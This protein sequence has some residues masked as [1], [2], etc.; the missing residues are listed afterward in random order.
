MRPT[1]LQ[2]VHGTG[3][4]ASREVV[5]RRLLAEIQYQVTV[6]PTAGT[7][8]MSDHARCPLPL[9]RACI[10]LAGP[11]LF[12]M[13]NALTAL[14][15]PAARAAGLERFSVTIDDGRTG[16]Q[17]NKRYTAIKE[18]RSPRDLVLPEY[19]LCDVELIR[20]GPAG[21]SGEPDCLVLEVLAACGF[22]RGSARKGRPCGSAVFLR[23][24]LRRGQRRASKRNPKGLRT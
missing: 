11:L 16:C 7:A 19:R 13:V 12:F 9:N 8:R 21:L 3:I 18:L 5:T 20:T 17:P 15:R 10:K 2:W 4:I 23:M 1:H 6:L 14:P 22:S 24:L